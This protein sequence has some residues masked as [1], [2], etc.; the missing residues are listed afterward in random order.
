L[1]LHRRCGGTPG[2]YADNDVSAYARKPRP[3]W[4][5]LAGDIRAG[6]ITG[7][8]CWHVDRLTRSPRQL[9]D[10]ID[11]AERNGVELATAAGEI[12]LSTRPGA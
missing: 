6:L 7:I 10:V 5:R 12:N 8:A 1:V 9:E 3:E 2:I 4:V 11:L